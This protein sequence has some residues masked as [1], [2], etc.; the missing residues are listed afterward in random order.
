MEFAFKRF[1]IKSCD[2]KSLEDQVNVAFMLLESI[3]INE[4]IVNIEDQEVIEIIAKD[5]VN[6]MLKNVKSITKIKKY[7]LIF[8][9]FIV[10]MKIHF[11]FL[12]NNHLKSIVFI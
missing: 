10:I 2:L 12:F 5:V 9:E 3:R 7:N 1:E 6:E 11:S 8:K 4:K